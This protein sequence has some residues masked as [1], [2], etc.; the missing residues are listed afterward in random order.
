MNTLKES[1]IMARVNRAWRKR[2]TVDQKEAAAKYLRVKVA[3]YPARVLRRLTIRGA[4]KF[5]S[6]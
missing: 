4:S 2:L 5:A 3:H 1:E 6:E